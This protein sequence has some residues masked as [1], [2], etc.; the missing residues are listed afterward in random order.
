MYTASSKGLD[1]KAPDAKAHTIDGKQW[2]LKSHRGK[3]II[4]VFWSS[5]CPPCM[6]EIPH[7]NE[8][9][10]KYKNDDSIEI[11]S[12][13]LD[14]STDSSAL[15]KFIEKKG[16]DYPVLLSENLAKEFHVFGAPSFW[17]INKKGIIVAS[18]RR[19]IKEILPFIQK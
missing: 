6:A 8:I 18:N 12:Y 13:S 7:I 10:N 2:S 14:L 15:K 3:T 5:Y 9:Y 1:T 19:S 11:V 17:V 4:I 16:I